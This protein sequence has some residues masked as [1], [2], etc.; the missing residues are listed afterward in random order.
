MTT[1]WLIPL[2]TAGPIT[3]DAALQPLLD[4]IRQVE[5]GS[6]PDPANALGDGGRSLGPYQISRAYW[7]DS[8]VPGHYEMVRY[9]PYAERVI[10]AYWRRHCP[11]ALAR[12]D[13]QVLAR[14]HNG[15]PQG[16]IYPSTLPYWHRVRDRLA[17][18]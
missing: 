10:K 3:T 17:Q 5:T 14:T 13:F 2:L 7:K 15:G 4:A 8:G 6:H 18:R 11:R 1:I 16:P 12:L 9:R